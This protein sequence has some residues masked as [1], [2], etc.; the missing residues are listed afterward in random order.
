MEKSELITKYEKKKS[1]AQGMLDIK[2]NE[3][4]R[5]EVENVE[6]LIKIFDGFI[7][8]LEQLGDSSVKRDEKVCD[9]CGSKIGKDE[10][11]Y[12]ICRICT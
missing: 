4:K 9:L 1:Y 10:I 11:F 3:L 7:T 2:K 5:S 6:S 8:D 12:T